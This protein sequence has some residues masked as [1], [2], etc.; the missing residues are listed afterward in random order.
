MTS[1]SR[2]DL[3]R[4]A[5]ALPAAGLFSRYRAMAAPN[6][7]RV[8]ITN[9]RAKRNSAFGCCHSGCRTMTSMTFSSWRVLT[10]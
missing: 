3:L 8:K 10:V 2:R 7:S 1:L 6:V 5:L 4:V 9:V